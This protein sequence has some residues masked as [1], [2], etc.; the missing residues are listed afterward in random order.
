MVEKGSG[1]SRGF[2]FV[3]FD[4]ADGAALAIKMMDGYQVSRA[5]ESV[6]CSVCRRDVRLLCCIRRSGSPTVL[7]VP[8]PY[9]MRG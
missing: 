2:G 5:L 1:R 8:V 9:D 6:W 3:S 7:P 4:S